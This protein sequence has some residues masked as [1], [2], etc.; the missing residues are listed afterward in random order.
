MTRFLRSDAMMAN[1]FRSAIAVIAV[2]LGLAL[3]SSSAFAAPDA[4]STSA[5]TSTYQAGEVGK[6]SNLA[7]AKLTSLVTAIIPATA[8]ASQTIRPEADKLAGG[9]AVITIVLAFVRF[10]ASH[11][12][13]TAWA[14]LFE[15]LGILGIF[16][17]IYLA[18]VTFAP[19]FYGWFGTLAADIN[20]RGGPD[21]AVTVGTLSS[22]IWD[23]VMTA[24]KGISWTNPFAI[25]QN[26]F[27]AIPLV[28]AWIV[29]IITSA[30]YFWFFNVGQ[31]MA[32][33]GIVMGQIAFALAFSVFTRG[34]F[35]AW[36]DYMISAGMYTVVA[37]ILTKLVTSSIVT[38]LTDASQRGV[39]TVEASMYVMD[40]S[41]FVLMLSFEIPKIASMFGGG[42]AAS[43]GGAASKAAKLLSGG[44]V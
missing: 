17:S 26:L 24:M 23:A 42:A 3:P 39:S 16:A 43:G 2:V 29:L 1:F 27:A 32:G 19:A 37:A 20:G 31:I 12:P 25:G 36:L 13:T 22:Q 5:T 4:A 10:A 28:V 44:A 14:N 8:T 6:G 30:I 41:F 33:A 40:L 21:G 18:Y 7:N 34:L 11:H 15:E 38:A 35:R 9:L